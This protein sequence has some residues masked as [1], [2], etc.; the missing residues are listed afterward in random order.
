MKN[1][2]ARLVIWVALASVAMFAADNTVG[3]WKYNAAKSKSTSANPIKSQTDVREA[4]PDGGAK[5]TRTTQYTDGTTASYS[6]SFKYDGKEYP[7]T[8]APY[9]SVS[10]KR[11]DANTYSFET[12]K[13]G[14]KYHMKGQ[15]VI[16][17]DGKTLTQTIRGTDAQGKPVTAT[18]VFEKQ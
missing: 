6:V 11:I 15:T 2:V 1:N 3:T 9:D 12:K 10:V 4:T 5:L 17:K 18:A 14:G 7:A 16:S 8:G 13:A